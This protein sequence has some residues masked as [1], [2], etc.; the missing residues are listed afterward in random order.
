M[1]LR[2][3]ARRLHPKYC[4]SPVW[5]APDFPSNAAAL[6]GS[7]RCS[8]PGK[9]Y[10]GIC[11]PGIRSPRGLHRRAPCTRRIP[12]IRTA[13]LFHL[14]FHLDIAICYLRRPEGEF[15][16]R[17]S[18]DGHT[19]PAPVSPAAIRLRPFDGSP[20]AL[21]PDNRGALHATRLYRSAPITF[22]QEAGTCSSTPYC[23]SFYVS[24]IFVLPSKVRLRSRN[25]QIQKL[26]HAYASEKNKHKIARRVLHVLFTSNKRFFHS[27]SCLLFQSDGLCPG[28][29]T[30]C[31]GCAIVCAVRGKA[32]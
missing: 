17:L 1:P 14:S 22:F 23:K 29:F 12:G 20:V 9:P 16:L 2:R 7:G 5:Q 24:F 21:P 10:S 31:P 28:L 18:H 3:P 27:V 13:S 19:T 32:P 8:S 6:H 15:L 25:Q 4:P 11:N 26:L 30:T